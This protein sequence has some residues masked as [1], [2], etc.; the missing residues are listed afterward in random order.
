MDKMINQV[1]G[2]NYNNPV[3]DS[4]LS[5]FSVAIPIRVSSDE[6]AQ[7]DKISLEQQ[8]KDA[9]DYC[10]K[11][12]WQ[13]YRVYRDVCSGSI[14]MEERPGGSQL[15]KDAEAGR[16]NLVVV[17]DYDRIGRDRDGLV[18]DMFRAKLRD[19]G[20]Q[21]FSLHQTS[22]V[23]NPEE[24]K[25]DPF[26]EGA[27][28]LEKIHDWQSSS[29][30]L[31]FIRRSIMGKE[32]EARKGRLLVAPNY[33]LKLK[34]KKDSKGQIIFDKR[35]RVVRIRV[36]DDKE[37]L[38]VERIYRE[39]A[40]NGKSDREIVAMLNQEG[41]PSKKGGLWER[42]VVAR[43]LKNPVYVGFAIYKKSERRKIRNGKSAY[44]LNPKDKWII[45]GPEQ[46]EH[47]AIIE[48]EIW[49]KAQQVRE[50]KKRFTSRSICSPILFSGL[51]VCGYCSNVMYR[52]KFNQYYIKK[53]T[54]EKVKYVHI[55]YVCSQWERFKK[56]QKNHIAEKVIKRA[57]LKQLKR[58]KDAPGALK[59]FLK[60]E[61]N[62]N[63]KQDEQILISKKKAFEQIQTRQGRAYIAYERGS[64]T[65]DAYNQRK[66]ELE[67]NA[68][69]LKEDVGKLEIKL[70]NDKL[71]QATRESF[72]E[73]VDKL[74]E[75]FS[76][77]NNIPAQKRFLQ[78]IIERIIITGNK[79]EINYWLG[80]NSHRA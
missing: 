67:V 48:P 22:T 44:K 58:F 72:V 54:G 46:S 40:Q 31:K 70:A 4:R 75:I 55:A 61:Q 42:Q 37:A 47:P 50:S 26:D 25:E 78:S 2:A 5:V 53:T 43:I 77:D 52:Q 64:I 15:L 76:G 28:L 29:T 12:E 24:F 19:L 10:H 73:A 11:Q 9:I 65:I 62:R 74:D 18:A 13:V 30:I 33:G 38:V 39:Y 80:E 68:K 71:R 45:V 59:G 56:C 23:K 21:V 1:V 16:V 49:E 66:D 63:L 57:V 17:W 27:I 36:K 79:I 20:I 14:P 7:P 35:G 34:P 3:L 69:Q 60:E 41:I 8:E 32:A 51:P 6:Q